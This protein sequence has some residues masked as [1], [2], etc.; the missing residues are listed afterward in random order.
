MNY[1][2]L[3]RTGVKVS[4]LCLG[5]MTFGENF[6]NIAVVDQSSAD[7]MVGRAL[8]AGVNF[9]DT[10][11]VYSY[12]RSEEVLA[13]ALKAS[14]IAR[15][16]M[17][18]AT[19][20]RSAMSEAATTGA[21]DVNNVGL[22]RQHIFAAIE[23]SLRRLNTDYID[24]YQV[25]GWDHLTP[26]EET[27]RALDDLVRQGKVRYVG[28]SNWS[29]RHLMKALCLSRA[30]G[31]AGFVSLQAYYS[32]VG[33]DLEHELLPL[34][35]EEGIGVLP[36][37]PLS[38]GFLSGKYGRNDP[39]PEG[40]RRTNFDFPP[41]DVERGFDAVDALARIANERGATVAQVALAWLLAQPGVTSII[42]GANKMSQLDDN[43]K[44]ADLELTALE[45]EVLSS[46]TAPRP[47]YP[48]W[49]IER[50]NQGR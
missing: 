34:C 36:W 35:C 38:G 23:H 5:T 21:G 42:I 13:Q 46:T 18:I 25:H 8:D 1:R 26:I 22:S 30:N 15:D 20:V 3:G 43:L 49:M 50:Q 2:L 44:A 47:L 6:F 45:L 12:G 31:W 32:L 7:A 41:I 28:C 40:A 24:L 33:R 27:L 48:Q 11:D 39:H 19:K 9:F 16:E 37:S 17:I 4:E 14:G 10:A 29:V